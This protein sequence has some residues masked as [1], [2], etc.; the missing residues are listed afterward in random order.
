MSVSQVPLWIA[1]EQR[2]F[3][4]H[5]IDA[6]ILVSDAT[7]PTI[8]VIL[9]V[10]PFGVVGSPAAIAAVAE[11]TDLK[12]LTML[13]SGRAESQ[14]VV[15]LGISRPDDLRGKRFGVTG[16]GKGSWITSILALE[17]LELDPKRDRIHFVE[18]GSLPVM[19]QSLQESKIDAA[20]LD[21]AHA[22]ELGSQGFPVLLDMYSPNIPA[23]QS[24]LVVA[25]AYLREHP[26]VAGKVV[27][28]LVESIAFSLSPANKQIVVKTLMAHLKISDPRRGRARLSELPLP[29]EPES[30]RFC[31]GH[32]KH[33]AGDGAPRSQGA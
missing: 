28:G 18:L 29:R 22:T 6:Q 13:G 10:I 31:G 3:A 1:G 19:A 27:A 15:R 8:G 20:M 2:L 21:P 5:G 32:E 24:V 14:L 16:T 11:G 4:R 12:V 9:G 23:V 25:S 30:V 33:A 7:G 26:H 17:R